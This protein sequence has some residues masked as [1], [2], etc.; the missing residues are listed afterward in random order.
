MD[1]RIL[2]ERLPFSAYICLLAGY[3]WLHYRIELSDSLAS[4]AITVLYFCM[5]SRE[6]HINPLYYLQ[7]NI[8]VNQLV[9]ITALYFTLV[10]NFPFLKEVWAVVTALPEYNLGFLY[11]IPLLV[12]CLCI[13]VINL[14][15]LGGHRYLLKPVLITLLLLS[16]LAFYSKLT[17]GVVFDYGMVQN[18]LQ[19]HS[20]EA[21][22]YLNQYS[23]FFFLV[24]GLLPAI[25]IARSDVHYLSMGRN[26]AHSVKLSLISLVTIVM[27]AYLYY[28]N[29]ASVGRNNKFLQKSSIPFQYLVATGKYA[30]D[31]YF[32]TPLEF[33]LLDSEPKLRNQHAGAKRVL[34]ML[35]VET[36]R[37]DHFS[38]NGY[39][40][41]TNPYTQVQ[42]VTSFK[43][44]YSCGT[45]TAVSI[46]C[47][48]SAL[49]REEYDHNKANSQQNLLDLVLLAGV[50]VLWV[51]NNGCKG[52]CERVPTVTIDV[53]S[54]SP[55]CDGD[56]CFDETLLAPLENKLQN[57]T[58][59]TT[60]IVLHMMGSHGPTYYK[61][62]PDNQ[63]IFKDDCPRSDIQNCST[64]TLINTYDNTIAYTDWVI[65]KVIDK[66]NRLPINTESAMLYVSDHGESLGENGAYLHG[67]PYALAPESQKHVPL[68]TWFAEPMKVDTKCLRK[69]AEQNEFSHD[70][71]FHSMLGL[72]QV[73][74]S[75]YQ[76][77]L[78]LFSS[79]KGRSLTRVAAGNSAIK[80]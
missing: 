67:F 11:S 48:F 50:D 37:A 63:R 23:V 17:Y 31:H 21:M 58:A 64:A 22:M 12:F 43:N 32:S 26:V 62:Y 76:A 15:S 38:H 19:S 80:Q 72:L 42:P 35:V 55:L 27:I 4:L 36:A 45:A 20:S 46:P 34:V 65:S 14:L 57:L 61:R 79:C 16:S 73:S 75:V 6:E 69:N 39:S 41:Q 24:S 3:T 70:N 5:K 2:P 78:D 52:V 68:L 25:L 7:S 47:M 74:S 49:S 30:R 60:L 56:Y 29:Y 10:F 77:S 51:D 9:C 40:K 18:S 33:K 1:H 59:S 8:S 13:Q 71:I 28:P 44:M 66:L 53:K 54:D